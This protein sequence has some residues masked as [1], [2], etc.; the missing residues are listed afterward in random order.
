MNPRRRARLLQ[1]HDLRCQGLTLRQIADQMDCA[2]STVSQY[3]RD[4]HTHQDAIIETLAADHLVH[5]L[6][7]LDPSDSDLHDRHISAARE[8]RLLIDTL[9]RIAD[10]QQRRTRRISE[11]KELDDMKFLNQLD[12]LITHFQ[13]AGHPYMDPANFDPDVFPFNQLQRFIPADEMREFVNNITPPVPAPEPKPA[14]VPAPAR[15][16]ALLPHPYAAFANDPDPEP[17]ETDQIRTN[18]NTTE[19]ENSEFPENHATYPTDDE[20][21]P[22]PS[23]QSPPQPPRKPVGPQHPASWDNPLGYIPTSAK[24]TP[25]VRR[26]L[27][28]Q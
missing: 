19:Q 10:R 12:K 20:N 2:H 28:L 9:D 13:A 15:E 21:Y 22:I 1:A 25:L 16:P 26:A 4:F 27:G 7:R 3:L 5:S 14:P 23:E 18:P 11:S 8:L 6:S 24:N 17:P